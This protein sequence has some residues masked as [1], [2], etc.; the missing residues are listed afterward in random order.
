M[1]PTGGGDGF[2]RQALGSYVESITVWPTKKHGEM[3]LNPAAFALW[4]ENTR[5]QGAGV[6]NVG[7]GGG[8]GQ[9]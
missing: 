8:F 6:E 3:A 7:S 5:P 4:K 2:T 9:Q 1:R